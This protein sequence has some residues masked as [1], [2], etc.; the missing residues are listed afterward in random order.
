MEVSGEFHA[1]I[2]LVPRKQPHIP[3]GEETSWIPDP[4]WMLRKEKICFHLRE[5]NP[6]RPARSRLLYRRSF[7]DS[8]SL[9]IPRIKKQITAEYKMTG[10]SDGRQKEQC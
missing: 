8:S 6:C 4:V 1:P 9:N 7:L 2:A 3:I 5:L 10:I